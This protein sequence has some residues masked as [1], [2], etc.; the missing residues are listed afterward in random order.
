MSDRGESELR[1]YIRKLEA[2]IEALEKSA[3][4]R[5]HSFS[6]KW[7]KRSPPTSESAKPTVESHGEKELRIV[8]MG[9]PGAGASPPSLQHVD[10]RPWLMLYREG[11]TIT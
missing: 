6:G 4:D 11:N 7:F 10:M 8:L 2:R 5:M 9:P 3:E 1:K